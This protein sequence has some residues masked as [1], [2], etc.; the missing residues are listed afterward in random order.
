MSGL[1][2]A[3]FIVLSADGAPESTSRQ[4]DPRAVAPLTRLPTQR[5][6]ENFAAGETLALGGARYLAARLPLVNRAAGDDQLSS[7]VVLYPEER[8]AAAR[9]QAMW[10]PLVVGAFAI[11]LAGAVTTLLARRLVRPLQALGRQAAAIEEGNFQPLPLTR[12]NDE[13]QDLARSINH[14]VARLAQYEDDVRHN[15]RLRT[16]GQLGAGI[17]HQL[18]NAATGARLAVDL[19]RRH[20]KTAGEAESLEI[21]TQQLILMETY[22]QRFLTLGHRETGE[23]RAV[24]LAALIEETLPLI[25]PACNHAGVEL[26][27]QRP[28]MPVGIIGDPQALTQL[29]V[30][31]LVNAFEAAA[32]QRVAALASSRQQCD[33]ATAGLRN[34]GPSCKESSPPRVR[35]ELEA[36]DDRRV[37]CRISDSGPG[38]KPGIDSRLF[39]PFVTDKPDGT[40]L[41]LAMVQQIAAEHGAKL[42]WRR[43]DGMT[44]FN[45]IFPEPAAETALGLPANA[46]AHC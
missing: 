28:T 23:L 1:S 8:W 19:H 14:M 29:L 13:I 3:D 20:C 46:P 10:P 25:R 32:G 34:N 38:P 9:R 27:W 22:L 44:Q 24:D 40:G 2:G 16:L 11:L 12:R 18:R 30:N 37:I 41:G 45:V 26:Q 36:A 21:A 15:E 5:K 43:Q 31:L 17:A 4:F 39:E 42:S 33:D 6:L 35:I 7:L